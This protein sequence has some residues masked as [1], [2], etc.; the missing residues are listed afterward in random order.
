[1]KRHDITIALVLAIT[2][3]CSAGEEQRQVEN[4][5]KL[6]AF[7]P[8]AADMHPDLIDPAALDYPADQDIAIAVTF[9]LCLSSSCDTTRTASCTVQRTGNTLHVTASGSFVQ[10]TAGACSADCGRLTAKCTTGPLPTQGG[11]T[12]DGNTRSTD[13]PT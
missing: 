3:G 4:Q 6:C 11:L 5:G 2:A 8:G 13:L 10:K 9:P 1:M 7:P 12:D